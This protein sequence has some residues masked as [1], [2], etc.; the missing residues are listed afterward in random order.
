[1]G[2]ILPIQPLQSQQYAERMNND[3]YNF[4]Y[5]NRVHPVQM[6]AEMSSAWEDVLEEEERRRQEQLEEQMKNR[7]LHPPVKSGVV[8]P[9]PAKLSPAI[10]E[11]VGKGMAINAYA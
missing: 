6:Q 9:N 5:I 4:A 2:Y 3:R 10:A 7:A 11:V 1:M 8:A